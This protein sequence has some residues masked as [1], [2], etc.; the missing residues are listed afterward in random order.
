PGA[1][2]ARTA[3][4]RPAFA[5]VR[6]TLAGR[7]GTLC[8]RRRAGSCPDGAGRPAPWLQL[9]VVLHHDTADERRHGGRAGRN[10]ARAGGRPAGRAARARWKAALAPLPHREATL[11]PPRRSG[12]SP[13]SGGVEPHSDGPVADPRHSRVPL[14]GGGPARAEQRRASRD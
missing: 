7:T 8:H 10:A 5:V 11:A 2:A 4:P 3:G 6:P 9:L 13:P 1:L 12:R 14:R